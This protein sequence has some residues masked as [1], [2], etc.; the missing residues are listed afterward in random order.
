MKSVKKILAVLLLLITVTLCF[1]GCSKS[2]AADEITADT[3][4]IAYTEDNAPFVYEEN[5]ELKGF[6]VELFKTI[7][8]NIKNESKNYKFVKVDKDY[9][10]GEDVYCTTEDGKDCIAYVMIGGIQKDT[11]AINE[12]YT[13]SE[14]VISNRIITV[15]AENSKI[16]TYADLGGKNVGIITDAAKTALD[17]HNAIKNGFKSLTEY[18]KAETA[19][20]DVKS[21]KIDAL[22]ID[23]FTYCTADNSGLKA[24]DGELDTVDY[25]YAFK[26][27][28]WYV[29]SINEAVYE[30]KSPDY[31]DA[32][33]F[34][35]LVE[36]YFGYN[37]SAFNY[38]PE[39]N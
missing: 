17:K 30:L 36:K 2:E 39:K 21:G 38:Q 6:D 31:N 22:I 3:M 8:D 9:R 14:P 37:A 32:D 24:L 5:G 34:T 11:G 27:W 16:G 12:S 7:F 20:A 10:I 18:D 25:V 33:E 28:D 15:T 13:L 1:V 4:L 35:P 19:I 23:E 26:K 29:D